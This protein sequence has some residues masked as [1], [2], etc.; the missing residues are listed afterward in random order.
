L[1]TEIDGKII[2]EYIPSLQGNYAE[3]YEGIYHSLNQNLPVPV[4]AEDGMKV[5][6]VIEAAFKS[7]KERRVVE[8]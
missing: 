2:K 3:Y 7:N 8:F 4:S 6:Q 5:I 1:H